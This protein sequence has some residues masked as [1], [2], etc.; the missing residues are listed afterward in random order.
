MP[1]TRVAPSWHGTGS[2]SRSSVGYEG[3]VDAVEAGAEAIGH[4]QESL[5]HVAPAFEHTSAVQVNGVVADGLDTQHVFALGICLQRQASEMDLE[6]GE[7][8][9]RCP[10]HS[11]E[12]RGTARS[13]AMRPGLG[14]EHGLEHLDV[15]TG[16]GAVHDGV[17]DALHAGTV[18]EQQVA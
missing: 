3:D 12:S 2:S 4:A 5:G 16:P 8:I 11:F 18:L 6:V 13:V 7:V 15:E 1:P 10:D 9:G 17:E 14:P